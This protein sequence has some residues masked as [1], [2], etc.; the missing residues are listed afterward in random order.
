MKLTKVKGTENA[1]DVTTKHVDATTLT[2]CMVTIGLINRTRYLPVVIT[3]RNMSDQED[4]D[5]F[6]RHRGIPV[7]NAS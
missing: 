5:A 2:K 3:K 1:T 7:S 4:S 6:N